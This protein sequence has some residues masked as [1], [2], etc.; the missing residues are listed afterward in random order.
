MMSVRN[1]NIMTFK[2]IQ[3]YYTN[4]MKYGDMDVATI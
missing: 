1:K 3:V 4:T 2:V